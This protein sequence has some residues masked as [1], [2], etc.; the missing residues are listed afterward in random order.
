MPRYHVGFTTTATAAGAAVVDLRTAATARIRLLEFGLFA[1]AATALT[2]EL[3]RSTTIGTASTSVVPVAGDPADV[4]SVTVAGTAW[5]VA[6]AS[7][8]VPIRG[9]TIPPNIGAGVIWTFPVNDLICNVSSSLV[10]MNRGAAA[11]PICRGY[12]VFDE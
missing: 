9:M 2:V 3:A 5:S 10:V 1:T 12:F 8:A 4:A 7:T 11:G 6:P